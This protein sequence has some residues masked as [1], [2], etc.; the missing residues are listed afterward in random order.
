[1]CRPYGEG[2][3]YLT[4]EQYPDLP[5]AKRERGSPRRDS[6]P[7]PGEEATD[8]RAALERAAATRNQYT[9]ALWHSFTCDIDRLCYVLDRQRS[10]A[11]GVPV[12]MVSRQE[13]PA[14][15]QPWSR[16]SILM[17]VT[18]ERALDDL[19]L[20]ILP[21]LSGPRRGDE[22]PLSHGSGRHLYILDEEHLPRL[23]PL[24]GATGRF[25]A[26]PGEAAAG[27]ALAPAHATKHHMNGHFHFLKKGE[28]LSC[29]HHFN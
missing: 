10:E 11:E 27:D 13:R 1:M 15:D 21:L 22:D 29:T 8:W 17:A 14:P 12:L 7:A 5:S 25:F 4:T 6:V 28:V 19:D 18:E 23:L 24:L 2:Q 20:Q 3:H 16:P 26:D 9:A